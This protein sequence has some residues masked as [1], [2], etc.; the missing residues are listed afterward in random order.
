V[1]AGRGQSIVNEAM[2]LSRAG[3]DDALSVVRAVLP[4]TPAYAWPGLAARTGSEVWVKHENHLPIGAFKIRGGLVFVDSL[5]RSG[6]PPGLISA[7]RGNHGQSIALA[8]RRAGIPVTIVVPHGNSREKNAAMRGFGAELIETG[9][10]FDEAKLAAER[11]AVERGLVMVPSFHADLVRGVATYAQELFTTVADIDTVYVPIGLGSGISGTILVRDL[12]GLS[13]EIVGV[14]AEGADAYARSVEAGRIVETDRAVTV[15]DGMAV[16]VPHPDAFEIIRNGAARIVRVSD[17]QIRAAIRLLHETTHNTA[18]GA[19]A[20]GLAAL[21]AERDR[22]QG[23]RVAVIL[24]GGNIDR[25]T[26]A[27]ILGGG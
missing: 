22:Q 21:L 11:I 10:D 6:T 14:V 13:T 19:G 3:L 12:L 4:P 27:E 9:A 1:I 16:R 18:E 8:G 7:T 5:L 24:C 23:R 20:A 26:Y 25:A 17:A 15:A 2:Q